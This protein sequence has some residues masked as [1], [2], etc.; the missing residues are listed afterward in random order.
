MALKSASPGLFFAL[1][2]MILVAV[3]LYKPITYR[4][5]GTYPGAFLDLGSGEKKDKSVT[6]QTPVVPTEDSKPIK[7]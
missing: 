6:P 5:T 7:K 2:G 1:G 4:E 3:S